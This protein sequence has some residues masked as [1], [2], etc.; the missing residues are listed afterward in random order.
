MPNLT[1]PTPFVLTPAAS[2]CPSPGPNYGAFPGFATGLPNLSLTKPRT[3]EDKDKLSAAAGRVS[4]E[5]RMRLAD[6]SLKPRF[7]WAF[8]SWGVEHVSWSFEGEYI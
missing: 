6:Y 3:K 5:E 7:E 2:P 8:G 1:A 4:R